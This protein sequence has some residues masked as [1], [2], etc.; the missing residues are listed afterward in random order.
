MA[1]WW[2]SR[3]VT[4]HGGEKD[5]PNVK[6][7][8]QSNLTMDVKHLKTTHYFENPIN[9]NNYEMQD[10]RPHPPPRQPKKERKECNNWEAFPLDNW[11]FSPLKADVNLLSHQLLE[12]C[13]N[14]LWYEVAC[15]R[16]SLPY[17]CKPLSPNY[18]GNIVLLNCCW[19]S[20]ANCAAPPFIWNVLRRPCRC[21]DYPHVAGNHESYFESIQKSFRKMR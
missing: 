7:W 18:V 15:H 20:S 11:P 13:Q 16:L 12:H 1:F 4:K 2:Q 3:C 5:W 6:S 10:E 17:T 9:F 19:I 8:K 14:G 21:R